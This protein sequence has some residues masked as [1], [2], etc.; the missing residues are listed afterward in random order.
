[1]PVTPTPAELQN[2]PQSTAAT[3]AAEIIPPQETIEH[4]VVYGPRWWRKQVVQALLLTA[5]IF[6]AA[7]GLESFLL[8]NGFIDGGVTGISLLTNHTTH[9]S[10]SLLIVVLNIPFVVMGYF[11]LGR[12]FAART[13]AAILGLALVLYFVHFPVLAE[14]KLLAA[15]FG[16]FFLGSGIGLAVRGG[17]VLDGTEILAV[18]LSKKLP[19]TVG[20]VILLINILI[21]GVAAMLLS[22]TT[23]L[24]SILAYL[25]A[26][27]MVDFII[28][29]IEEYT[30]V[31]IISPKSDIIRRMVTEKPGRGA[32]LYT[33]KSGYATQG[34]DLNTIDI[35]FTVVTRLEVTRLTDEI[36][37]IDPHAFVVMSSVRDTKGGIVKRRPLH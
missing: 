16:G 1:M 36:D 20:D 32:T 10:L 21:F 37:K 31:T 9:I 23:A 17:A 13:L 19:L 18:Y 7:L 34:H 4:P 27:K 30:G 8:P 28:E 3:A 6:S 2:Q 24:Y 5:G 12:A 15:V 25:A 26:A 35:I 11:Q 14:D 22:I 33:G 29:G